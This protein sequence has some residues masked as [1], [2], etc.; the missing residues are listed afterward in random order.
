MPQFNYVTQNNS[1][2]FQPAFWCY[3]WCSRGLTLLLFNLLL[4]LML[5]RLLAHLSSVIHITRPRRLLASLL[6]HYC[7]CGH[8]IPFMIFAFLVITSLLVLYL[9]KMEEESKAVNQAALSV[10]DVEAQWTYTKH[11]LF[12]IHFQ[13]QSNEWKK[14]PSGASEKA[15]RQPGQAQTPSG[16]E[17]QGRELTIP[18]LP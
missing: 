2:Y 9:F 5:S 10:Q 12:P 18:P 7:Y 16:W 13:R 8:L 11:I 1:L 4:P 17:Q 14:I 15:Q 3:I 6:G